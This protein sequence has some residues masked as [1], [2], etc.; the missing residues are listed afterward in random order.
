MA[1]QRDI[2]MMMHDL[3]A[4]KY[5]VASQEPHGTCAFNLRHFPDAWES[6]FG[7]KTHYCMDS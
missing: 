2:T 1:G 6:I 4:A 5:P 7:P 3:K